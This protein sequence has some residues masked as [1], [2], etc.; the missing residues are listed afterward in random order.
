MNIL[1]LNE[2]ISVVGGAERL[3]FNIADQFIEQYNAK[4]TFMYS[5]GN[6]TFNTNITPPNVVAYAYKMRIDNWYNIGSFTLSV[7]DYI[8]VNTDWSKQVYEA[9]Q[10]IKTKTPE[11]KIICVS[12][13]GF[14]G[15]FGDIYSEGSRFIDG[16]ETARKDI[17]LMLALN[18]A[19]VEGYRSIGIPTELW[20]FGTNIAKPS[21]LFGTKYNRVIAICSNW[22]SSFKNY[23][24]TKYLLDYAESIGYET[25]IYGRNIPKDNSYYD[26]EVD[27]ESAI[28]TGTIVV[29]TSVDETRSTIILE[30][31]I[32]NV[33]VIA[34]ANWADCEGVYEYG[35]DLNVAKKLLENLYNTNT[36]SIS[37]ND[38]SFKNSFNS[39][40]KILRKLIKGKIKKPREDWLSL[41]HR[42][43][44]NGLMQYN[45]IKDHGLELN[46]LTQLANI[47]DKLAYVIEDGNGTPY[48]KSIFDSQIF[49]SPR[50][51]LI[52]NKDWTEYGYIIGTTNGF[53]NTH[54][55]LGDLN[56][57]N[58]VIV[59]GSFIAIQTKLL[60][61][62]EIDL[63][64]FEP[65]SYNVVFEAYRKLITSR[66]GNFLKVKSY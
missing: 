44:I 11:V 13:I 51:G 39:L 35:S 5:F 28:K 26:N 9:I 37:H 45:G 19:S 20:K 36:I 30:A 23:K 6:D 38:I 7:Y 18:E 57:Y 56:H 62:E 3:M 22:K 15:M 24:E 25:E 8:F 4:V 50:S 65:Q 31:N 43:Y 47:S 55:V 58:V 59:P 49:V 12:N 53:I 29:L 52:Q 10:T 48:V 14:S 60:V 21:K 34:K 16:F 54:G 2:K 66:F 32:K 42:V 17:D 64:W 61:R 33:P 40:V 1:F 27:I 46:Y 63:D 41:G